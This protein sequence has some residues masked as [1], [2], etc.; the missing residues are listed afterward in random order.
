[1]GM[2]PALS[3]RLT[4]VVHLYLA[5]A[6]TEFGAHEPHERQL[7]VQLSQQWAPRCAQAE[8]E[9]VVDTA[10]V[11]ARSGF[12][13]GFEAIAEDLCRELPPTLCTRLLT[14]LGL[15][16]RADGHVT[17]QEARVISLVRAAFQHKRGS[18]RYEA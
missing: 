18:M 1:M 16:A 2:S 3:E 7:A 15:M 9:A 10:Y 14:D 6:H 4:Q 12:S 8:I 13:E 11:A 5:V 17:L